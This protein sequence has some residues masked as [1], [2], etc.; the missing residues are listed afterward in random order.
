MRSC[1]FVDAKGKYAHDQNSMFRIVAFC[2]GVCLSVSAVAR[3]DSSADQKPILTDAEK[4]T[5]LRLLVKT[6]DQAS[7]SGRYEEAATAYTLAL[8]I[9][10]DPV[11]SGRRGLVLMKLGQLDLAGDD[12]YVAVVNG[13]GQ[14]VMTQERNEVTAAYDKAKVLTAWVNIDISHAGAKVTCD[15]VPKNPKGFATFWRFMKPGEHT[16]NVQLEGYEEA[17]Q[18]FTT[19]AGDTTTIHFKLVPLAGP[20]LPELPAPV[21]VTLHDN[22]VFPPML[23]ASNV[24]GDP[25]YDPHEDPSYGEP[26]ETKSAKKKS[27]PRFSVNGGVVTVFGVASWNPAV[28]GVVGVG[29]RPNDYFSLGIEGRAAWLTTGV[30]NSPALSAM[31]A[32]GLLS[33][34][35]HLRWF[36]G[37]GLGY[38]GTVNVSASNTTYIEDS[39]SFVQPGGGVR[40]GA[41]I[42]IGAAFTARAGIDALRLAY[43]M[44]IGVGNAIIV[45][46]LPAMFGAQ[47]NGEW[48]F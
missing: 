31:T 35:G 34:C 27:G 11:I 1:I 10:D 20:K 46:Q 47:I 5:R 28:G 18:T 44:K 26:K 45:D 17:S 12:L 37:C 25:N 22:R 48:S 33:A 15:G 23:R 24:A 4:E 6:G 21:A 9:Q 39:H 13:Q 36:F 42:P 16:V 41:E 30:A 38:V 19:T 32:G 8:E 7:L 43:R 14:G 29:L 3:A 40:I 2:L